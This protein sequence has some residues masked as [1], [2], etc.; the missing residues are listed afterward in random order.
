MIDTRQNNAP[1]TSEFNESKIPPQLAAEIRRLSH[2]LSNALEVILQT[3]YLLG[4]T[5][6]GASEDSQ[7]WREMLDKGVAQATQ[8][9]RQLRE[10]IR[11][12]S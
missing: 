5:A 11:A 12:N 2:D 4:M 7:K 1:S 6:D 9:N 8:V 10:Y 3:N